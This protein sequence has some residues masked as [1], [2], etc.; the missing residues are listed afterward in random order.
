[1]NYS[2]YKALN[3]GVFSAMTLLVLAYLES[4]G[5]YGM[6]LM[7]PFGATAVL[8]FGVPQSPLA[9][10]K[11]V[12][13]GHFLTALI[14]VTFVS[15]LG[16]DPISIALATGFAITAMM[17][18]DTIHP[19]AGANPILIIVTGQSWDFLLM[20]VLLGTVFIVLC[21]TLANGANKKV[22]QYVAYKKTA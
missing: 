3:A 11:N 2:L 1:M 18:T 4:V 14:G 22:G 16:S 21:G 13:V 15:F 8:V 19:A 5:N 7:A 20:P 6:W 9:K 17:L 10:A 12:I